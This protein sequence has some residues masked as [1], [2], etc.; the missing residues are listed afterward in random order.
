VP[1][2]I[3]PVTNGVA[4]KIQSAFLHPQ[5]ETHFGFLES[6]LETSPDQGEYFCGKDL[7]AADILMSFPLEAG[8][9]PSGL[10]KEQYPRIWAYVERLHNAPAYKRAVQKIESIE[11]TFKT[12]L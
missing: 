11:G 10:S 9:S 3:K 4:T 2:F 1:F 7:T 12:N 6:L 5:F 8:R